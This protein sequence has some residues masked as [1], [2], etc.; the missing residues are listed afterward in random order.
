MDAAA[1]EAT[2]TSTARIGMHYGAGGGK[3]WLLLLLR[4]SGEKLR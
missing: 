4:A 1:G 3:R 2:M